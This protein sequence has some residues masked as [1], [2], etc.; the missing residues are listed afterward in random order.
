MRLVFIE[1]VDELNAFM[2][3]LHEK[4]I[5]SSEFNIVALSARA[6]VMLAKE[7]IR[8]QNTLSYFNNE[9]HK[10]CL[11]KSD[12]IVQF[13]NKELKVDSDLHIDGYKNWYIFLIR[14]L[15][16][17]ILWL[18]EIVFNAT[19]EIRPEKILSIKNWSNNYH[20]PVINDDERYL[21]SVVRQLCSEQGC[22]VKEIEH[23]KCSKNRIYNSILRIQSKASSRNI[24]DM[25]KGLWKGVKSKL[26]GFDKSRKNKTVLVLS[27]GYNLARVF[28]EIKER[29]ESVKVVLLHGE[30]VSALKRIQLRACF[31][32]DDFISYNKLPARIDSVEK[33]N[34]ELFFNYIEDNQGLFEYRGFNFFQIIKAKIL[35]GIT[36]STEELIEKSYQMSHLIESIRP[37]LS[38]SYASRGPTYVLGELCRNNGL[39]AICIPHGTVVPP[40]NETEEIVNRNI[41]ESVILN[42][43]P[44]VAVQTPLAK[45]FLN[46]CEHSS[47]DIVT[48][49]LIFSRK[50]NVDRSDKIINILH[51]VTLKSRNSMKFWGVEH[52]DEFV[53]SLSDLISVV[54]S[55][56]NIRLTVKLHPAFSEN[57]TREDL[58]QLLP[59]AESYSISDR[60]LEE[61]LSVADLV[62]SFSSTVIEEA[63]FES[64]KIPVVLYD[65]W[66]RYQHYKALNLSDEVFKPFPLYYINSR[67]AL[68]KN[69]NS[70]ITKGLSSQISAD[71]WGDFNFPEEVKQN[72]EHYLDRCLGD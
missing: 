39:N 54:D 30:P 23:G 19:N 11:L 52:N 27:H 65:K 41:G 40:K 44:S 4:K 59:A 1:F 18:I 24:R 28:G 49:P 53:S 64:N 25:R 29:Y 70:I 68:E 32:V 9:S 43:Y 8:F 69:I 36:K 67:K 55:M 57:F 45:E 10:N 46:H 22:S 35:A 2:Q 61:E 21:S 38:L 20:G 48:G 15:V 16:N 14:H 34:V 12:S 66:D 17:H 62:V 71:E 63:L 56:N 3:Y 5:K 6:Q 72:Y 33:K 58:S 13:L 26:S 31:N 50:S 37:D 47:E 51:A 7:N 60:T 42:K